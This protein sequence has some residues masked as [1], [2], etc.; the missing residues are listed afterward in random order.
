MRRIERVALMA[1]TKT[2]TRGEGVRRA[3]S[4]EERDGTGR[5]QERREVK[6]NSWP[7]TV[8]FLDEKRRRRKKSKSE[9][10]PIS[11]VPIIL[12]GAEDGQALLAHDR[13]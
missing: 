5:Q 3:N 11:D 13:A 9:A 6:H 4:N 1:E 12:R 8:Q 10:I 7:A 2:V